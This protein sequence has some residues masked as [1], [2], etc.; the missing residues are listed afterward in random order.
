MKKFSLIIILLGIVLVACG[1]TEEEAA[2]S[3]IEPANISAVEMV[4]NEDGTVTALASGFLSDS[5]TT[6]HEWEQVVTTNKIDVTLTTTRPADDVC[7]QTVEEFV[8]SIVI[9][10]ADLSNG[11]YTVSVNGVAAAEPIV[12]GDEHTP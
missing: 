5:C 10:T 3:V 9:N 2:E 12:L 11:E 6:L 7:A 8:E 1:T 4:F